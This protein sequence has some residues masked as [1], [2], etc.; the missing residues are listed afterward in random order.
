MQ[1]VYFYYKY[2]INTCLFCEPSIY[3]FID[4][5]VTRFGVREYDFYSFKPRSVGIE[6]ALSL[7]CDI[8]LERLFFQNQE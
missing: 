1:L 5:I 4:A 8:Y 7:R 6:H 3:T 2:E